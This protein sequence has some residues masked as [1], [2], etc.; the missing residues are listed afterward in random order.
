MMAGRRSGCKTAA[1]L[2]AV[3]A[4]AALAGCSFLSKAPPPPPPPP[5]QMPQVAPAPQIVMP[6][7]QVRE[8]PP[9]QVA[10]SLE[11]GAKVNPDVG[12]RAS[13]VI[14]RIYELKSPVAFQAADF[15]TLFDKE[16][17]A[18]GADLIGRDEYQLKPGERVL[19][20]RPLRPGTRVVAAVAA[21]RDLERS[22]WKAVLLIPTAP[23]QGVTVQ[24]DGR[25]IRIVAN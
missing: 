13:P 10:I 20:A 14:V 1:F 7:P 2:A 16:S 4:S 3:A 15:F 21:F 11:A 12:G 6:P 5:F 18:L 25:Q 17:Q 19:F 24:V 23:P 22:T 9:V 8:A